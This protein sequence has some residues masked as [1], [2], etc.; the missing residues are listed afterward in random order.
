MLDF[1]VDT[2]TM[3]QGVYYVH[4]RTL[5]SHAGC[6]LT[7]C[8]IHFKVRLPLDSLG[9]VVCCGAGMEDMMLNESST[10]MSYP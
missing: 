6:I 7:N 3:K 4:L 2:S 5:I 1:H 8:L 9:P 10:I